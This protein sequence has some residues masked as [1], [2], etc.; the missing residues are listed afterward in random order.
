[1]RLNISFPEKNF[2]FDSNTMN[3]VIRRITHKSNEYLKIMIRKLTLL[4]VTNGKL[5]DCIKSL[6]FLLLKIIRCVV[7]YNRPTFVPLNSAPSW[8]DQSIDTLSQNSKILK[9]ILATLIIIQLT[10]DKA[11]MIKHILRCI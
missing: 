5:K 10:Q 6:E 1:M 3:T 4:N 8:P 2:H 11:L 7:K 9:E